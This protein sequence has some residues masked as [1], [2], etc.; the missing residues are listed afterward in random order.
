MSVRTLYRIRC[1][2]CGITAEKVPLLPS[3]APFSMRFENAV[4]KAS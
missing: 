3:E 2:G 4:E 1:L